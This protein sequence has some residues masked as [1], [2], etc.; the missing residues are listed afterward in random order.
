MGFGIEIQYIA[1]SFLL[2]I[3]NTLFSVIF[4]HGYLKD[5]Y[6]ISDVNL[7]Y[8]L[9]HQTRLFQRKTAGY[10]V[11]NARVVILVYVDAIR[12][13]SSLPGL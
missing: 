4:F 8:F 12:C 1:I 11:S 10:P 5:I 7:W 2:D 13:L 3:D 6:R 9:M